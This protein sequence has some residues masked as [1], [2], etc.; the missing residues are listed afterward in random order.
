MK[1]LQVLQGHTT[2]ET[3]YVVND[4]PYGFRLRCKI[5]YWLEYAKGRGFRLCS[6]TTNPKRPGEV[7]NAPKKSTYSMLAVMGLNNEGHVTWTGCSTYDFDK[8]ADFEKVYGALF[9]DVQRGVFTAAQA[10]YERYQA[11][12][13][14]Q[15]PAAS[16]ISSA[17]AAAEVSTL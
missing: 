16:V 11:R 1:P 9:D 8:L 3:A 17:S 13:A 12:K 15:G 4:Y 10:A 7:W 2:I 14:P 5:R 6:Q